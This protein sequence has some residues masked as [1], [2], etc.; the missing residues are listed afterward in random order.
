MLEAPPT[1]RKHTVPFHVRELDSF[2][3]SDGVIAGERQISCGKTWSV[4]AVSSIAIRSLVMVTKDD[5]AIV[6]MAHSDRFKTFFFFSGAGGSKKK[7]KK[8]DTW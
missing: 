5:K 1:K 4:H 8:T 7:Q 2:S 3:S 6:A